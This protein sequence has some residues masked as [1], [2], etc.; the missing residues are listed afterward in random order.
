MFSSNL[1]MSFP[2]QTENHYM[3]RTLFF[4]NMVTGFNF[5]PIRCFSRTETIEEPGTMSGYLL[6]PLFFFLCKMECLLSQIDFVSTFLSL[7]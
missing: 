3:H 2:M 5:S 4:R 1:Q 7:I 6:V